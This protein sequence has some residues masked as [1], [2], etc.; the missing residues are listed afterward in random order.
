MGVAA[1]LG[2]NLLSGCHF[3][4]SNRLKYLG[5]SWASKQKIRTMALSCGSGMAPTPL[6]S[7]TSTS[8]PHPRTR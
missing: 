7:V 1:G 8:E 3:P 5:T 2:L 4:R 6:P